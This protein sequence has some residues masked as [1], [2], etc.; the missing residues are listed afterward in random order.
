MNTDRLINDLVDEFISE[1]DSKR[2]V[3]ENTRWVLNRFVTWMVK[4]GIDVRNPRRAD[5]IHYKQAVIDEGK[6]PT[7]VNRYLS[8]IRSFFAWLERNGI[9]T[10]VAAGIKSPKDN[11]DFRK[12]YL[13][14]DQVIQLLNSIPTDRITGLRDYAI[15]NLMVC[16][17]LRRVEVMRL[18]IADLSQIDNEMVL[19]IQRKGRT[20]KEKIKIETEVFEPIERYLL[21]RP[22]YTN[23]E[24]LFANHSRHAHSQLSKEMFSKIVKKYLSNISTS[25]RLTCHSLRHSAAINLLSLGKSIYDVKELLGHKSV[26]TTQHYLR[27]IEAERRYNNPVARDLVELY[28]KAEKTAKLKLKTV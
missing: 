27:A 28:R 21:A 15:V 1:M 17:G 12:D 2:Y 22:S 7:T 5:I 24:P 25:K 23:N 20:Y 4:N 14:P 6:T 16:T 10:N 13:K 11:R 19:N 26:E 18:T 8:P 9:Y 3:Q